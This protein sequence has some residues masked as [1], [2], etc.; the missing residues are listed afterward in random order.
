M[1]HDP[2]GKSI[3]TLSDPWKVEHS[4][5]V[6]EADHLPPSPPPSSPSLFFYCTLQSSASTLPMLSSASSLLEGIC[7]RRLAF[8]K[9]VSFPWFRSP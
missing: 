5:H 6:T 2:K 4:A 9:L 1:L 8:P 3:T 7:D